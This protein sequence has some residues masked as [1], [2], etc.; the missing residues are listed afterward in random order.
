MMYGKNT[1]IYEKKNGI[2]QVGSGSIFSVT[3]DSPLFGSDNN[4]EISNSQQNYFPKKYL[5]DTQKSS[6]LLGILD[7]VSLNLY[8][9]N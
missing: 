3:H 8:Y 2:N 1:V 4:T 5:M 6:Y 7:I 9:L